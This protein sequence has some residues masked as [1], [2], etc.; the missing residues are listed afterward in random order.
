MKH[1]REVKAEK[2]DTP[3]SSSRKRGRRSS[4]SSSNSA[5]HGE[6]PLDHHGLS[7]FYEVEEHAKPLDSYGQGK[8]SNRSDVQLRRSSRIFKPVHH[9]YHDT[10][11]WARIYAKKLQAIDG[12]PVSLKTKNATRK[13]EFNFEFINRY[14]LQD[15]VERVDSNFHAGCGCHGMC[16]PDSCACL[17]QEVNSENRIV[18]Y[19]AGPDGIIVLRS[20]FIKRNSMLYECS[21]LCGCSAE[22]WN[23]VVEA[24]RTVRFEIFETENRGLGLRS[25]DRICT[26]QYIDCYLGEI[27]TKRTA[28]N[29]E[30]AMSDSASYLF[31]LDFF[32][33]DDDVYVVDGR[34]YGSVTRFMNHSCD[35]NSKM[36]SVSHNHADE[37]V[38]EMAFFALKEIPPYTELTFDYD[39]GWRQNEQAEVDPD[40]VKCLCG[41][42]NCRGQLWPNR[43]KTM[44]FDSD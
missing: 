36:L 18:P 19:K 33:E 32:S 6:P 41:A 15:G 2:R 3:S 44:Q 1:T 16:S 34:R 42:R 24:G 8:E 9:G 26:G 23:R 27:I 4:D 12:P 13:M 38:F 28:D 21:S 25:P 39:P 43:R 37:N 40:A 30:D 20:D 29:R 14:K 7:H 10:R 5:A 22:C 35:P 11:N 17:S 31:S